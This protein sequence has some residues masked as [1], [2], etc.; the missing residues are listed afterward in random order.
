M[1]FIALGIFH[2]QTN[3]FYGQSLFLGNILQVF[4][5]IF[6]VELN[7]NDNALGPCNF[8]SNHG[9]LKGKFALFKHQAVIGSKIWL[10]LNPVHHQGINGF[11]LGDRQLDMRRERC[12]THT[13]NP[14]VLDQSKQLSAFLILPRIHLARIL[15][16]LL[17]GYNNEC[18]TTYAICK[19]YFSDF[20]DS[21]RYRRMHVGADE[22]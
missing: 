3:D 8:C 11:T 13:D 20:L 9:S 10:T 7:A 4:N 1:L 5:T 17:I 16:L 12:T 21:P 2:L 19:S 15:R 14:K 6:L 22:A 18:I